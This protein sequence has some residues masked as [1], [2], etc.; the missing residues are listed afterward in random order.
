MCPVKLIHKQVSSIIVSLVLCK[1]E[2]LAKLQTVRNIFQSP[3]AGFNYVT[4]LLELLW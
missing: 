1:N 2:G 4:V 3:H